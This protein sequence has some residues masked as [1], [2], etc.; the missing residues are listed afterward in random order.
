MH[1][2]MTGTP[3]LVRSSPIEGVEDLYHTYSPRTQSH[4]STPYPYVHTPEP[5]TTADQQRQIR[6]S[7]GGE[8]H[9]GPR[10][11][12]PQIPPFARYNYFAFEPRE[13]PPFSQYQAQDV[14]RDSRY[15]EE[16][17]RDVEDMN[18]GGFQV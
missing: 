6:G 11:F 12:P 5:F 9:N 3:P 4:T 8:V 1:I 17:Y 14:P 18:V 13:R 16:G 2:L 15:G 10:E 7:L